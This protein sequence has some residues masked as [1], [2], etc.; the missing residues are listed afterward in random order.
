MRFGSKH[1]E[2][3]SLQPFSESLTTKQFAFSLLSNEQMI[4][5]E[6]SANIESPKRHDRLFLA[7]YEESHRK[8][9]KG[10]EL[11]RHNSGE[12]IR[13]AFD[14]IKHGAAPI[15][16]WIEAHVYNWMTVPRYQGSYNFEMAELLRL[17]D[18]Q[19]EILT[20]IW[21]PDADGNY[22]Y[23][24]VTWSQ[25]KKNGKTQIAGAVGAWFSENVEPPNM[26]YTMASNQ[27]QSAGLIFNALIPSLYGIGGQ[28]PNT[29]LSVPLIVMPNGTT[30]RAIP[31]NY[32]GQAGGSYGLTLWSELWTYKSERDRRLWE[33]M[34]PVPTRKTSVRWVE[35]YAGF[36]NESVLLID[37]FSRIFGTTRSDGTRVPDFTERQIQKNAEPVPGLEHITAESGRPS[38]W[39]IPSEGFFMFWDDKIR[40]PWITEKYVAQ[41]KAGNR[42]STF[43]RLWK[44]KWQTSEGT[45]IEPNLW[46]DAVTLDAEEMGPM[47]LAGDASQRN[48]T[49]ALVGVEKRKVKIFG[50]EQERYRVR[51]VRV[52]DPDGSDIDL[53][54]TIA[55]YVERIYRMGLLVGAFRYDPFQMHQVAVNLRKRGVPCME[56][57][58]GQDRLKADTFLWKLFNDRRIDVYNQTVLE[59]HV[60]GA[61]AK[62]YENEQIRIIKGTATEN[63]KVDAAVALSMACW[64]ASGRI[65]RPIKIVKTSSQS[66]FKT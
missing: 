64:A 28:T 35:T 25:P 47:V 51:L 53:D 9:L 19:K 58:Q 29:T 11:T 42:H 27:E 44:N 12:K 60:K 5:S 1:N 56:F 10:L 8:Q 65:Q 52:W 36:Q 4:G 45:F 33:E 62:E 38:C 37:Q 31:N 15:V 54:D 3:P 6:L 26:I 18:Y 30:I 22:P 46:D 13:A 61:N 39:H 16:P 55:A 48:D 21:T 50:E 2:L 41:Q 14:K 17:V 32:A 20:I 23:S 66:I 24:E 7:E 40:G 59:S 34:P 63:N 57:N 49:T 43:V